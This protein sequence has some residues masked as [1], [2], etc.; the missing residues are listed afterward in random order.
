M[1]HQRVVSLWD[2]LKDNAAAFVDLGE[3][4]ASAQALW[5]LYSAKTESIFEHRL[6]DEG[7]NL[8]RKDLQ[9]ILEL[10]T[11]LNLTLSKKL[12]ERRLNYKDSIPETPEEFSIITEVLTDELSGKLFLFVPSERADHW[13]KDDLLSNDAK[14]AFPSA[15]AELRAAGN[16]Y[17]AAL[18]TGSVFYSMR[19]VEHGLRA[20][21]K[22]VGLTFDVQ[23]W[24]VIID[25]IQREIEKIRKNGI[26]NTHKK[27]KDERLQFL[28][29]SAKEF[30]YF[31]DGWR[32]Y[33][34][35]AKAP[36][37]EHQAITVLNHVVDFIER[38]SA[39]LRE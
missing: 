22:D 33:V 15:A 18:H 28:S 39:R 11:R 1:R 7:K 24:H 14:A 23:Q 29:E 32:N 19:A 2:M 5:G 6:N 34:S 26:Q 37:T 21:S 16:A 31:K 3:R 13:E 25:Q 8:L 10:S 20:M 38:I 17:A 30:A 27:E 9:R 35:H 12:V 4:L 36:Y